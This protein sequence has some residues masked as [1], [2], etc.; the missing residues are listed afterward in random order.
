MNTIK[1]IIVSL[2]LS[3]VQYDRFKNLVMLNSVTC[4]PTKK[5]TGLNIRGLQVFNES[6][7]STIPQYVAFS[8]SLEG[9]NINL[10]VNQG[11]GFDRPMVSIVASTSQEQ[12]QEDKEAMFS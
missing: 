10:I 12:S 7:L 4:L 9:S 2:G 1:E 11:A 6:Q 3:Q 8:K 5:E